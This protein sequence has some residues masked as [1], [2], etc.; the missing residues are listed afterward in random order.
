MIQIVK[1]R[2]GQRFRLT[3]AANS[4]LTLCSV[5]LLFEVFNRFKTR[6]SNLEK[7]SLSGSGRRIL[8]DQTLLSTPSKQPDEN[9]SSH[10]NWR[11]SNNPFEVAHST[12]SRRTVKL[13]FQANLLINKRFRISV[14]PCESANYRDLSGRVK[15]FSTQ[16]VQISF[17]PPGRRRQRLAGTRNHDLPRRHQ[18]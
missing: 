11:L 16:C 10:S 12:P 17:C 1:E 3:K 9:F 5:K 14:L 2:F 4:T 15:P 8:Q 18:P 13:H 7:P 6:L